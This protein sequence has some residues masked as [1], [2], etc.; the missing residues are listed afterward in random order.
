MRLKAKEAIDSGLE[1]SS[2]EGAALMQGWLETL[3]RTLERQP[4]A[5]FRQWLLSKYTQ[6]DER[7]GRYWELVAIMKGQSPES[8]PNREWK[9]VLAA[10]KH[11]LAD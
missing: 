4:D 9:W 3:A 5:A 7:G 11:H 8:S 1:P 6:H 2:A 10:M